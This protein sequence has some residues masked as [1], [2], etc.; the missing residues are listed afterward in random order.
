MR[1]LLMILLSFSLSACF[2]GT[3]RSQVT[4]TFE[5]DPGDGPVRRQRQTTTATGS[6]LGGQLPFMIGGVGGGA[7]G[8]AAIVG[9]N[10]GGGNTACV[11][12]PDRCAA[13]QIATVV[14]PISVSSS[15]VNS[16]GGSAMVS[17]QSGDVVEVDDAELSAMLAKHE[18]ALARVVPGTKQNSRQICRIIVGYAAKM[19]A[20]GDRTIMSMF[21]DIEERKQALDDCQDALAKHPHTKTTVE[22]E[23]K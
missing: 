6:Y 14:Q 3:Q 4:T 16:V 10:Y 17:F 2:A 9:G 18:K 8:G 11:L 5:D 7:Y 13:M 23:A 21:P 20:D 1:G 15:G 22:K 19:L 12:H